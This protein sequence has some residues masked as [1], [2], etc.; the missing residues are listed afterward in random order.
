M[1][2]TPTKIKA[3]PPKIWP[4]TIRKIAAGNQTSAVPTTGKMLSSAITTPQSTGALMPSTAN[5]MP[6]I[7]PC[8]MP[9]TS[10][11]LIVARETS[12]K[13]L[14]QKP[15]ALIAERQRA[16]ERFEHSRAVAQ[17]EEQEI[18][19]QEEEHRAAQ[20]A[21][22]DRQ[23]ALRDVLARGDRC[24]LDLRLEALGV[25]ADAF[26]ECGDAAACSA[27]LANRCLRRRGRRC[28]GARTAR[29]PS[30][31]TAAPKPISGKITTMTTSSTLML[32]ASDS[33]SREPL[34]EPSMQWI[35]DDA[36]RDRPEDRLHEAADQ[37]EERERDGQQQSDE[38]RSFDVA[39]GHHRGS[40]R[41]PLRAALGSFALALAPPGEPLGDG[42]LVARVR[43]ARTSA[44]RAAR[45]ARYSWPAA[46]PPSA[47]S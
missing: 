47:W 39:L 29:A 24:R 26:E 7:A 23:R 46:W 27:A 45:R 12:A 4:L 15:L 8:T 14:E 33:R 2:N 1:T 11:P 40:C 19:H 16:H 43:R 22:A 42:L 38:E 13:R 37:P 9:T 35:D 34:C 25:D 6:P 44:R 28:R 10:V 18:E 31:A 21:L 41:L 36:E 30:R 32:A 20:R 5:A 17:E 3:T